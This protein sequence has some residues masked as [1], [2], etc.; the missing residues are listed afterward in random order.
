M[1]GLAPQQ[2][3]S[4]G[5]R[6]AGVRRADGPGTQGRSPTEGQSGDLAD[7]DTGAETEEAGGS[8]GLV[9]ADDEGDD[10]N[11]DV[12]G[13]VA[14]KW[15]RRSKKM[16]YLVHWKGFEEKD[17]TWE[18]REHFHAPDTLLD[19]E[20][21]KQTT[22]VNERFDWHAWD[23]RFGN[24]HEDPNGEISDH[25]ADSYHPT[26]NLDY[27]TS[28]AISE[29]VLNATKY[30]GSTTANPGSDNACLRNHLSNQP[31]A[32]GHDR[33]LVSPNIVSRHTSRRASFSVPTRE[34]DCAAN[35]LKTKLLTT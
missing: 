18:P 15:D 22:P 35:S 7:K 5:G 3:R 14:E 20:A 33:L 11:F 8:G 17:H 28:Q 29:R 2:Q 24:E 9:A 4:S 27:S 19:W 13:I 1:T 26:I 32:P 10:D 23:K 16:L 6:R 30:D 31:T 12:E 25:E 34:L 21:F